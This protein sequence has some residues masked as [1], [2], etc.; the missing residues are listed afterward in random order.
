LG[1]VTFKPIKQAPF[2]VAVAV[3]ALVCGLQVLRPDFCERLERMTYDV[4]A[5][6]A[7]H[8]PAPVATN[9]AFVAIQESSINAV[10]SGKLGYQ[11]GLLWPRQVYGRLIGELS[12]EGAKAVGFDVLFG[13]LRPDQQS[14][15][16]M[17]D[18]TLM[19]SDDYFA[20]Q[21]KQASNVLL[22]VTPDVTPPGLF[23]TNALA[24]GDITTEKDPDGVLRRVKT[25]RVYRRW[26]PYI[27][28]FASPDQYDLDLDHAQVVP[29]KIIVHQNGKTNVVEIPIDAQTNF[30][31]VDLLGNPL[32]PG[33]PPKAR[34][35]TDQIIWHM[36]IVLASQQLGLDLDKPEIDLARGKI[37]LRG[38][39]G[40][41]RIIPVDQDG[42][43][44]VDWRLTADD[45]RL[46]QAPIELLLNQYR[47]R[48]LGKT[49]ELG[50]AFRNKLVVVG[51]AV[52]GN[53]LTDRGATPLQRD[54]LLVSK[55]WNVANSIITNQFIYRVSLPGELALIIIL[56]ALTTFLNLRLH[57]AV[58][59]SVAVFLLLVVYVTIAFLAFI[60][61]RWW[62]PLVFP[63][64]GAIFVEH[65][66][67]VVWRAVFEEGE[68]RRVKSVFSKMV[69]P[70]IV[71]ELLRAEKL[72]LGGA[73]R[74]VTVFFA[75]VRGFT[76][77][78]D[79]VQERAAKYVKEHH[80]DGAAAEAYLDESAR[81]TLKTINTYLAL[82][83]DT[84]IAN[85]GTLDKYIGDC[86]MAFWGAPVA[87]PKH[88]VACV[89]A[90]IKAQ[91]GIDRLNQQ[92]RSENEKRLAEY[93]AQT[94]TEHIFKSSLPILTLGCGI[95]TGVVD[96]GLMGSEAHQYNYTTF[97]REVNL[98]SRL[99]G[100]AGSARIIIGETTHRHLLRD[101]PELAA[102]CIEQPPV[103][104]KGF[105]EAVKVY[106][107]PWR[108]A[109][110]P[111]ET[112]Q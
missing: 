93:T 107:V 47:E 86:V 8:F 48:L 3:I 101:D 105:N 80:L 9:L 110:K 94:D 29:G 33:V 54:T 92:R 20:Q 57:S 39:N 63:V 55:H 61:F 2:I 41:E 62:L 108:L 37:I 6:T 7:L 5:K 83:A 53:D 73:R 99:E 85:D 67:L 10:L 13:E 11:F 52:Q 88:A 100:V 97:G 12:T 77:L 35:F 65:S 18:G 32:P 23:L 96:V 89:R 79:E 68:K 104:I 44:Y 59:A 30:S 72:S 19:E 58:R 31:S 22:A 112:Q 69:S 1:G 16:A 40:V 91:R 27:G 24:L 17:S 21:M 70:D 14:P 82:V 26:H 87:N 25:Y 50:D 74:E 42:Y 36:G 38:A 66:T 60:H 4:R 49:N 75:D 45:R 90:A 98:A 56:G 46:L 95:N 81:D 15:V 34:A 76:A 71:S 78:T 111:G 51:S 106:E 43:F 109:P 64:V 84:L 28:Y 102:T 103:K